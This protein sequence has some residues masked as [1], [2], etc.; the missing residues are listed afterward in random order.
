MDLSSCYSLGGQYL[1]GF[2]TGLVLGYI[3]TRLYDSKKDSK[4]NEHLIEA[5]DGTVKRALGSILN[6]EEATEPDKNTIIIR[7]SDASLMKM[8]Q[9]DPSIKTP[10]EEPDEYEIIFNE[11]ASASSASGSSASTEDTRKCSTLSD[12]QTFGGAFGYRPL[13]VPLPP[14]PKVTDPSILSRTEE[15]KILDG[16]KHIVGMDLGGAKAEATKE[17]LSL[18]VL[19]VG[20]GPKTPLPEY[21]STT[22]GVRVKKMEGESTPQITYDDD[23]VISELIDVGGV[24]LRDYGVIRL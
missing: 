22:I 18:H 7:L 14:R 19:Y 17:N 20:M 6:V 2:V 3:F 12:K 5:P 16:L 8:L 23:S 1:Q 4:E 11:E 10:A 13:D 9:M 21:S 15:R 24:D